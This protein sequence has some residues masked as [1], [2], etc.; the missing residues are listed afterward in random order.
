MPRAT[1]APAMSTRPG[2]DGA[3]SSCISS[4]AACRPSR[5]V[6][7]ASRRSD[8]RRSPCRSRLVSM[9]SGCTSSPSMSVRAHATAVPVSRHTSG[10]ATHSAFQPR[11]SRSCSATMPSS[12]T[13]DD[14]LAS[15]AS[16]SRCSPTSGLRLCGMVML[17]TAVGLVGSASSP[18]SGRCSSTTSPPIRASVWHSAASTNPNSAIR[19]RLVS[20]DMPGSARPSSSQNDRRSASGSAAVSWNASA[21]TAP[22]SCPTAHRGRPSRIRSRW[23]RNSSAQDAALNP[24]VTGAPGCACV[25]PAIGVS[26]CARASPSTEASSAHRPDHTCSPASRISRPNQVSVTSCTVAPT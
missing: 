15:R 14:A 10:N 25:R 3:R 1:S 6:S 8:P 7:A 18:I 21:P 19:S 4:W 20:Q 24:K 16:V 22:A 2:T 23:R 11:P 5:E 12:S 13:D 9:A 26:R 17:P